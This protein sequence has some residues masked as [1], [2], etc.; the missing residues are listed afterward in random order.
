MNAFISG[1]IDILSDSALKWE[2]RH[3]IEFMY[4]LLF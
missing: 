1:N 3:R 2:F 4:L